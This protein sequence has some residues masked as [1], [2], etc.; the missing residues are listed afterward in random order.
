MRTSLNHLPKKIHKIGNTTSTS[1]QRYVHNKQPDQNATVK[2]VFFNNG[3]EEK[4]ERVVSR[5]SGDNDGGNA[6]E[7]SQAEVISITDD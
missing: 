6:K 3:K 2:T 1:L 7:I 4:R 5:E